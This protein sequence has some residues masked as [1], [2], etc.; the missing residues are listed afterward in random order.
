MGLET[1]FQESLQKTLF[2]EY[3]RKHPGTEQDQLAARYVNGRIAVDTIAN[4]FQDAQVRRKFVEIQ[5]SQKKIYTRHLE[6]F[7]CVDEN[8]RHS[9]C[10][11][12]IKHTNRIIDY[13]FQSRCAGFD[14]IKKTEHLAYL[15]KKERICAANAKDI[16]ESKRKLANLVECQERKTPLIQTLI[17]EYLEAS[18]NQLKSQVSIL[19][20]EIE[21]GN[22]YSNYVKKFLQ[23]NME[24]LSNHL[25]PKY[26]KVIAKIHAILAQKEID[27]LNIAKITPG[28]LNETL[29][30]YSNQL[31]DK[32]EQLDALK[33]VI[34]IV[35]SVV[36]K[37]QQKQAAFLDG[38]T[39]KD[40]TPEPGESG[41]RMVFAT[42]LVQKLKSR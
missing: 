20:R 27:I 26:I 41:K 7:L 5:K 8:E 28:Q 14:L 36:E 10:L 2:S 33:N 40:S 16:I 19:E 12:S 6:E 21:L 42:R 18:L 39:R 23:D 29:N 4:I 38:G 32:F 13:L 15:R 11:K 9:V 30:R 17:G 22:Q 34:T 24:N 37:I 25:D 31:D 1:S 3:V 35:E